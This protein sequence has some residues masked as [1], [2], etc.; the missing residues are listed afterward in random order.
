VPFG[1]FS[2]RKSLLLVAI[3]ALRLLGSRLDSGEL[4]P[5]DSNRQS[6]DSIS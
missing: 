3:A 6:K 5:D 2:P 4:P 1:S